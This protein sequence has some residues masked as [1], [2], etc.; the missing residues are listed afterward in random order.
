[1]KQ[2]S[3]IFSESLDKLEDEIA[4]YTTILI[5][6]IGIV[7][8]ILTAVVFLRKGLN[9][10]NMGFFYFWTS[11]LFAFTLIFYFFIYN[12]SIMFNY[13][14]TLVNNASCKIVTLMKRATRNLPPWLLVIISVERY[15]HLKFKFNKDFKNKKLIFFSLFI[16]IAFLMFIINI[17]NFFYYLENGTNSTL[18]FNDTSIKECT[19]SED[20]KFI[21]ILTAATFRSLIPIFLLIVLNGFI[22]SKLIANT[23]LLKE[24]K[25][26]EAK[27]FRR[28]YHFTFMTLVLSSFF[29]VLNLP[30]AVCHLVRNTY[31]SVN[32]QDTKTLAIIDF[33][34]DIT[35]DVS[36][37]YYS[38]FFF[39]NL[40]FNS[41]FRKE[42]RL[43]CCFFNYFKFSEPEPSTIN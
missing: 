3:E 9:K 39:I 41:I 32:S 14:L 16:V 20:L 15:L 26:K 27:M 17:T 4:Y 21:A 22:I 43:M 8:N 36:N 23:R 29:V 34:W 37:F 18:V 33:I 40:L 10:T 30:D 2:D 19:A 11:V 1:M 42:L 24:S 28:E 38:S 6:P 25:K 31:S 5:L 7:L 13:D 35:Y 12:S